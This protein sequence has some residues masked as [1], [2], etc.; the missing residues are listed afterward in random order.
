M[1]VDGEGRCPSSA[2]RCTTST[3]N[4][5][6]RRRHWLPEWGGRAGR[7]EMAGMTAAER[8]RWRGHCAE[9][10]CTAMQNLDNR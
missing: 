5:S 4:A 9:A 8:E 1:G 3:N 7:R 2:I 6:R 10:A